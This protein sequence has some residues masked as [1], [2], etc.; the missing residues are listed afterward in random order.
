VGFGPLAHRLEIRQGGNFVF[1]PGHKFAIGQRKVN[2]EAER[3][4]DMPG[5]I[6]KKLEAVAFRVA[7]IDRPGG[8][9]G[10]RFNRQPAI[11]L[12]RSM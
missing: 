5:G 1:G 12:Q 11:G 10:N 8:A 2:R 9:V 6:E 3:L 4:C 7:E